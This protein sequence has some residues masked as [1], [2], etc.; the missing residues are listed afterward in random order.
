MN[1]DKQLYQE[2]LEANEELACDVNETFKA[3]DQL[4]LKIRKQLKENENLQCEVRI[5]IAF[6]FCR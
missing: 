2:S 1:E 4:K 5:D 3:N 6:R